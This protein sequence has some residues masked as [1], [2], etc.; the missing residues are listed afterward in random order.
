MF[1]PGS[2]VGNGAEERKASVPLGAKGYLAPDCGSIALK[3]VTAEKRYRM[4]LYLLSPTI[5]RQVCEIA[6]VSADFDLPGIR[7]ASLDLSQA[8][9]WIVFEID[10]SAK[11]GEIVIRIMRERWVSVDDGHRD[12]SE[13]VRTTYQA[14]AIPEKVMTLV[15]K[16]LRIDPRLANYFIIR[17][18]LKQRTC[19]LIAEA[20]ATDEFPESSYAEYFL[21]PEP[22]DDLIATLDAEPGKKASTTPAGNE[23]RVPVVAKPTRARS[24]APAAELPQY[25]PPAESAVSTEQNPFAK[26]RAGTLV[27]PKISPASRGSKLTTTEGIEVSNSEPPGREAEP[28][29]ALLPEPSP[30]A[31]EPAH[32]P[33]PPHEPVQ[34]A[35]QASGT[36]Y[37]GGSNNS[38]EERARSLLENGTPAAFGFSSPP[39]HSGGF[40]DAIFGGPDPTYFSSDTE[41]SDREFQ[42]SGSS[43]VGGGGSGETSFALSSEGAYADSPSFGGVLHASADSTTS[44]RTGSPQS[45]SREEVDQLLKQQADTIISALSGS[46]AAQQR[47]IREG[48]DRQEKLFSNVTDRLVSQ[49][50]QSRQK[51]ELV[52]EQSEEQT[53]L[54]LEAFRNELASDRNMRGYG[55]DALPAPP[56]ANSGTPS[57]K[58]KKESGGPDI[59]VLRN[60][61]I[62]GIVITVVVLLVVLDLSTKFDGAAGRFGQQPPSSNVTTPPPTPQLPQSLPSSK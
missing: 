53:G 31:P 36:D 15:C 11:P 23:P 48:I 7:S 49:L 47:S 4:K 46:I 25:R 35:S 39:D 8:R 13:G 14:K 10:R 59:G 44:E 52:V 19:A 27:S 24:N 12:D 40:L 17:V 50:E 38:F 9:G 3:F 16:S 45:Y 54:K 57:K 61:L 41:S 51:L 18:N 5:T 1:K 26:A 60:M 62:L 43:S 21:G 55:A 22:V 2:I 30:P 20:N 6:G 32:E 28:S 56:P 34:P 29:P 58:G 33:P 42:S 37:S